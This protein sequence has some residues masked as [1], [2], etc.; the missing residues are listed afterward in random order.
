MCYSS[1]MDTNHT[2]QEIIQFLQDLIRQPSISGSESGAAQIVKAKMESMDFDDVWMD[3][4][5]SVLASRTG[6]TEGPRLLFDAHMD[7]VPVSSE[8]WQFPP[9]GGEIHQDRVWGRGATDIKGGLAAM[10]VSLGH[11][12]RSAFSGTLI[13]SASIGEEQI[14]GLAMGP[15]TAST[16]PDFA[17]ICEPTGC[18]L[19]SG[20]K[21]RTEFWVEVTGQPAHTSRPDLGEN[22]IY[23]SLPVITTLRDL[24]LPEDPLLGQ[25]VMELIEIQSSPFPGECIVPFGCRLRYDRR[26]VS[27]ETQES[28]RAGIEYSLADVHHWKMGFLSTHLTTYTGLELEQECFYPG[29]VLDPNT[30]WLQ[31][32]RLGL[33]SAGIPD[34]TITVPYC[35]HASYTAGVAGIPTILFG[36]SSIDL[37]HITDEYI[38]IEQLNQAA[39]G[40]ASLARSLTKES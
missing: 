17:V 38:E 10:I 4:Y 15:I 37:A 26:L 20:Q 8:N 33:R 29:W 14:E 11:L 32:A 30:I 24:A 12:A 1:S 22:A 36:P 3:E 13:L 7:V 31:R 18:H 9:F 19:A 2:Q 5:G 25:G 16:H 28:I 27:G 35:T 6:N 34:E 23:R 40:F 39:R 21:G